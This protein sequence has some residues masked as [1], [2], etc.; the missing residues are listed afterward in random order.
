MGIA[1]NGYHNLKL[2]LKDSVPQTARLT[3]ESETVPLKKKIYI[4]IHPWHLKITLL[5]LYYLHNG[6]CPFK[7]VDLKV[8][9]WTTILFL[10]YD[11]NT[12]ERERERKTER[13]R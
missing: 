10:W 3:N 11:L 9:E 6:A 4:Y 2:K 13:V 5:T 8:R 7:T 12:T 1:L